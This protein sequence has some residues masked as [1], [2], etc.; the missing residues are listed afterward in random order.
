MSLLP[1]GIGA[2]A[3]ALFLLIKSL[4]NLIKPAATKEIP[5]TW[6]SWKPLIVL[7]VSLS[8]IFVLVCLWLT[9]ETG[10]LHGYQ[11]DLLYYKYA[12]AFVL[13]VACPVTAAFIYRRI[14]CSKRKDSPGIE[15]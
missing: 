2:A 13:I 6:D 8:I 15:K 5:S 11:A 10:L 7:C 4:R 14:K 1:F 9:I 3:V 12:L